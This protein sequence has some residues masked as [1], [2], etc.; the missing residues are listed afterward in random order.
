MPSTALCRRTEAGAHSALARGE[1]PRLLVNGLGPKA[2]PEMFATL[3]LLGIAEEMPLFPPGPAMWG[4]GHGPA[5]YKPSGAGQLRPDSPG[6]FSAPLQLL[7]PEPLCGVLQC[8]PL[9]GGL[10]LAKPPSSTRHRRCRKWKGCT[11]AGRPGLCASPR[12]RPV[13]F[14]RQCMWWKTKGGMTWAP[15]PA[16]QPVGRPSAAAASG[17]CSPDQPGSPVPPALP[18]PPPGVP[19]PISSDG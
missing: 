14:L 7:C 11:Q 19:A 13:P 3:W 12:S 17:T 6:P 15:P 8:L 5:S 18:P 9:Q 10:S 16:S 4:S 2:P 1:K